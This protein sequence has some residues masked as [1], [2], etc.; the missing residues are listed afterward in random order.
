MIVKRTHHFLHWALGLFVAYLLITRLFIS[1]IQ[2]WPAQFISAAEWL[3]DTTISAESIQIEQ[4]WLGF[5]VAL[6][7]LSIDS[8]SFQF[9]A[10]N[11]EADINSFSILI[12]S[13]GYGD[14][15]YITKG[16]YQAKVNL[17]QL[18]EPLTTDDFIKINAKISHLWKK[19]RFKDFILSEVVRPGFSVQFHD[20]QS[21]NASML[22]VVTQFSLSYKNILNF[23]PF[24]LKSTFTPNVWGGLETGDF[25]VSSFRPLRIERLSKLLSI[26]WQEVLP[27]GELILDM[28]G[29]VSQSK[30]AN[31][32]LNLNTQ[33]LVWRQQ[34]QKLPSNVGMQLNWQA[35]YQNIKRDFT[36]WH[37]SLSKIQLDNHY[38]STVSPMDLYASNDG[39]LNFDAEYFDI[40]PFKVLVKSL[41]KTPQ[42]AALFDRSAFLSI[43]NLKGK[44][45]WHTLDIPELDILFDKLDVPVTDYPGMSL[46]QMQIHKTPNK[47][48]ISTNKPL[49]IMSPTIRNKPMQVNL[50]KELIFNFDANKKSWNLPETIVEIDK[51]PLSLTA[52]QLNSEFINSQFKLHMPSMAKLKEYLPYSLMTDRLK[53]WLTEGLQGG[54]NIVINGQM[55][56]RINDF[57][58]D[59]GQGIFKLN[60]SVANAKLNFNSKWPMLTNFDADIEFTPYNLKILV[61]KVDVKPGISAKNVVVNIQELHQTD[62]ALTV[63]GKVD[64]PL[65]RV[66]E[67]L[68]ESP[69]ANKIGMQAFFKDGSKFS[70]NTTVVLDKVWVP[71]SGYDKA[72]ETVAGSVQFKGSNIKLIDKLELQKVKG[73]LSF[74]EKS[75]TAKKLT[76]ETLKGS[77]V[78]SV[79]TNPKSKRVL[80]SA[81]GDLLAN[82]NDWFANPI[83]W[84]AQVSVPFK[85]S[86]TKG[87]SVAAVVDLDKGGSL[88]PA[89]LGKTDLKSKKLKFD[90]TINNNLIESSIVLPGLLQSELLWKSTKKGYELKAIKSYLGD[91]VKNP[92]S[93]KSTDSFVKGSIKEL[94]LDKW[95]P[96]I[97]KM[98]FSKEGESTVQALTWQKSLV[99][100]KNT[101]YFSRSYQDIDISWQANKASPLK[102]NLLSSDIDGSIEFSEDNKVYVDVQ[103]LNF[104]TNESDEE[105]LQQVNNKSKT[106]CDVISENN[107]LLPEIVFTGKN[108]NIDRRAINYISFK[109]I[110]NDKSLNIKE[111][112]GSFGNGA[113]KLN[114]AYWHDKSKRHS[115]IQVTLT[116]SNVSAVTEFLKLNKGF[117][118]KSASVNLDLNWHGGLKCFS[119]KK[120]KGNIDF[121][122]KEGSV[123]GVEPGFAR[124]IGLLS[125]ES[126]VRRLQLD[127]KDVTNKGMVYDEIIGQANLNNG[128]LSLNKLDIKAPSA[129]G[130]IF[131]NVDILNQTFDLE[132]EITPK[133]GATV[134]TI[135]ALAGAANPLTALAV[136]TLMKVIPGINENLVTYK[137]KITG[138]WDAPIIDGEKGTKK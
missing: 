28:K 66:A 73:K 85:S 11:L 100:I 62:I 56:G 20:F 19:I 39:F 48:V 103:R 16:A 78:A 29:N 44:L 114:G 79:K 122:I 80:V 77:G 70:G 54:E 41:I 47:M 92:F 95:I 57:P 74:T 53:V 15:L 120:A 127:L 6:H 130:S 123:E 82:R 67:Y 133:I 37:F 131:G 33:A 104:F 17:N 76:F 61:D 26:N 65:N 14:Y 129:I 9:Q 128:K 112:S 106:N 58:F 63:S 118:G 12:P 31:L 49:W 38:I 136:Y 42:I 138:P 52:E 40:E 55:K 1:W 137:Y 119:T 45:N 13:L 8:S 23:E 102:F 71:I 88:L 35:E 134:P 69:I 10:Q 98:G 75:V 68:T 64:A 124:L 93:Q 121:I 83:P 86:Q 107:S 96:L 32:E 50:P 7:Q 90:T 30:L 5:Q 59:N 113:G 126:L 99:S 2:F 110:D 27:K 108:I 3:T 25:S 18:D 125:V 116:S 135:A 51:M 84:H 24:N 105:P 34:H 43:S 115:V 21:I 46:Q 87:I 72:S 60:A 4:D 94:N 109:V 97:E 81:R 132:A 91:Y 22:S 101:I 111:I 89:P 36:D 117:S